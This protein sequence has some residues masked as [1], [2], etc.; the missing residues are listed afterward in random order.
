MAG[1]F[2]GRPATNTVTLAEVATVLVTGATVLVTGAT[3]QAATHLK[4][5]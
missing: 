5:T 3:K 1:G 2:G 4:P